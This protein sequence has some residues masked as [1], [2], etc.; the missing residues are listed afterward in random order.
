MSRTDYDLTLIKALAFDVDGVLSPS[1]MPLATDGT[2]MRMINV[3]D[4]YALQLAIKFGYKIAIITG[5]DCPAIKTQFEGLGITDVFT[6]VSVKKPILQQWI[7]QQGLQPEQVVYAGD[8][9]P[10]YEAMNIVGLSIAPADAASDIRNIARYISPCK[11][12][13]GVARD[14]I[15][16]L[17]RANR[18]WLNDDTAFGW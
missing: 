11:S 1:I 13:E 5:A 18:Q 8:D 9:I 10:D 17:L 12:G 14:I 15:E 3:K 16:Q 7:N 4:G 2:P 6:R